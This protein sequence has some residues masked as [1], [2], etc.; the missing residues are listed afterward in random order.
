MTIRKQ[1]PEGAVLFREEQQFRQ[2]WL[3]IF[4]GVV[5]VFVFVILLVIAPAQKKMS[6]N[7]ILGSVIV[8]LVVLVIDVLVFYHMKLETVVTDS[9]IF[10]RWFPVQRRFLYFPWTQIQKCVVRKLPWHMMGHHTRRIGW[11]EVY[12]IQGNMCLQLIIKGRRP[13]SIGSQKI[14]RLAD[15]VETFTELQRK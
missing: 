7:D 13:L 10:V 4:I 3:W 5:A 2:P 6:F 9:G 11:G 8:A 1:K 15:A 14:N 12:R